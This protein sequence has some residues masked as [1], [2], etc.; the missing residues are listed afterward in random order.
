MGGF[1]KG[2]A[3][4]LCPRL[5]AVSMIL[6]LLGKPNIASTLDSAVSWRRDMNVVTRLEIFDRLAPAVSLRIAA[7][8]AICSFIRAWQISM[9]AASISLK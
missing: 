1:G 4:A 8:I 9:R 5:G 7:R 3:G 6:P 2:G